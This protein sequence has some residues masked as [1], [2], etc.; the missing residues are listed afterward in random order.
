MTATTGANPSEDLVIVVT[1]TFD[2]P[3]E[4]VFK[5]WTESD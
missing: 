2:S 3:C 1:R 4:S 5:A